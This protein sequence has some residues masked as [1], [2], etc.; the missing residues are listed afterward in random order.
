[1]WPSV[2]RGPHFFNLRSYFF[3]LNV[4]SQ[5]IASV[6]YKA[7]TTRSGWK[8]SLINLASSVFK[9]NASVCV[10]HC[11]ML[12]GKIAIKNRAVM[13]PAIGALNPVINHRPRTISTTPLAITTKSASRGNQVGTCALKVSLAAPRCEKPA[14]VSARPRPSLAIV[15]MIFIVGSLLTELNSW[16]LEAQTHL[17]P[18]DLLD[19]L[20]VSILNEGRND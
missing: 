5:A 6:E 2:F 17:V 12:P 18:L 16:H 4:L 1:M 3:V 7:Q 15:R 11:E 8:K 13:V 19:L 14:S 20:S 10:I 9:P